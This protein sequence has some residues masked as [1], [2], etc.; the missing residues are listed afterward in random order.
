M[1]DEQNWMVTFT[2]GTTE[3]A[4]G[5]L[6]VEDGVLWITVRGSYGGLVQEQHAYPLAS[7]RK[8]ERS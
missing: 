6:T 8:W 2:D 7:L 4:Y 1:S 3:S 5:R